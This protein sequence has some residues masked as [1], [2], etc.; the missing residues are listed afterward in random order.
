[1][2]EHKL[3]IKTSTYQ[4]VINGVAVEEFPV[5][6]S[7]SQRPNLE[8]PTLAFKSALQQVLFAASNDEAR[9]ILTGL[10]LH[11]SGGQL[12]MAANRQLPF[13]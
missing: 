9:P 13:G 4:S 10:S 8:L 2:D 12:Y 5:M 1:L 11:D 3:H 7:N 6:P